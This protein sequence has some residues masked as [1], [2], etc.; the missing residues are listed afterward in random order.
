MTIGVWEWLKGKYSRGQVAPPEQP[1]YWQTDIH[2]HLLPGL[3]DGV[4][5]YEQALVC[6]S[7]LVEWGIGKIITTPHISRDIYPNE[8][9]LILERRD[10]LQSEV[11]R[12]N[13]AV[14]I[15]VAA[16]YMLDDFFPSLLA[17][18]NLLSFGPERYLL[19]ELG[20]VG[21]PR[22]IEQLIFQIL[23]KG[24]TP[25]LAHPERYLYYLETPEVL[26]RLHEL[27]CLFQLNWL[28]LT[29]QYG[30]RV[31]HQ[32]Q[33]L[34]KNNWVDF[35]G[36]DLHRPEDLQKLGKLFSQPVYQQ[37]ANQPLRNS[38]V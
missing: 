2:S 20:W 18:G 23:I 29:G 14:Q 31:N 5:T 17:N 19:V 28:S 21:S 13:I 11:D 32:A 10:K 6:I 22:D 25:V 3:D 12:A 37:I 33:L 36:S 34:L 38:Q 4:K 35:I 16:E 24:Y 9:D 15:E 26:Q 7:Q 27:G 1:C 8:A 30:S